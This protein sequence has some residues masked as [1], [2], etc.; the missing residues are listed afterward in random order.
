MKSLEPLLAVT[1]KSFSAK[2][3]S[4][5]EEEF[6]PAAGRQSSM[7]VLWVTAMW[8]DERRPWY[9]SFV[10]SQAQSLRQLGLELDVL[11]IPGYVQRRE[12]LRGMARL[13]RML[14]TQ[15][16]DL[17]HAHYGY[18]G[19]VGRVQVGVPL[20]LSYCGDDLLGTPPSDGSRLYTRS[21]LVLAGAF[22]KLAYVADATVTKSK[23]M[24][25][26]LPRSRRARNYVIPNGV[27]LRTFSPGDREEAR[28][29]LGWSSEL[30]NVLFVG[31][32]AVPR[33]NFRLARDVCTELVRR[34]RPVELR[35]GWNVPPNEMPAWLNAADALLFPSLSEGSP[36]TIKEA[37]ATELPIVSAPVGDVRERL[38]GVAGTFVVPHDAARMAD[39][40]L[41]ALDVG[42]SPA[43]REAVSELSL[44]R[45]AEQ[46]LAVYEGATG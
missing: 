41:A 33:K 8:P 3:A 28:R 40:L 42:R 30:P 10:Y 13:R 22:A 35:V 44:E 36:N 4:A 21:S 24:A 2:V 5:A 12:Y 46:V 11:Y 29:R 6:Q 25:A 23:A 20:I 19:V 37:M 18:C 7:R 26:H 31:N 1:E 15:S 17:V 34:G 27:D 38:D 45:V 39:A 14:K 32:P 43:A 16:Y 9:G